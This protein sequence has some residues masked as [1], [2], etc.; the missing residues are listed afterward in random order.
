LSSKGL[1]SSSEVLSKANTGGFADEGLAKTDVA[2]AVGCYFFT[3]SLR[4][5]AS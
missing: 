1:E 3:P 4:Y 2:A 5:S